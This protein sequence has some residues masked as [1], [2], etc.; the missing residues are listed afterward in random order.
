M[1]APPF[2][3][4]DAGSLFF[5][6]HGAKQ[7][8]KDNGNAVEGFAHGRGGVDRISHGLDV[9]AAF[10]E[11]LQHAHKIEHTPPQSVEL[12]EHECIIGL[13]VFERPRQGGTVFAPLMPP[14]L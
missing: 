5:L 7:L 1:F 13:E 9:N 14:S 11:I 6:V 2:G 8:G 12:P 10:F 3:G 4:R